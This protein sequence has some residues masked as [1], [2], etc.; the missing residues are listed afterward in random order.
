MCCEWSVKFV[1][2]GVRRNIFDILNQPLCQEGYFFVKIYQKCSYLGDGEFAWK[3]VVIQLFFLQIVY[4][5]LLH[6]LYYTVTLFILHCYIVYITLLHCLYY[7]VTLFILHCY[8][9]ISD[10]LFLF[11]S[12]RFYICL[13]P[14]VIL[15]EK[16]DQNIHICLTHCGEIYVMSEVKQVVFNNDQN[17][18]LSYSLF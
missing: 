11:T 5:T 6:C 10:V 4:I 2:D 8:I 18:L 16:I 12:F 3:R 9:V 1:W 14:P 13:L 15:V 7:T 17:H